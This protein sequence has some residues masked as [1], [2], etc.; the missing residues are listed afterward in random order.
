M[1]YMR[2]IP[3]DLFNEAKLLKCLGRLWIEAERNHPILKVTFGPEE[4][5]GN[6]DD[7]FEIVQD[8]GTG[9]IFVANVFVFVDGKAVH[10]YTGLNAREDWP[11]YADWGDHTELVFDEGGNVRQPF[12]ILT[13]Y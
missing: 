5:D 1:S 12:L 10:V 2:V 8:A 9:A 3:R 11:M 6:R 13:S 4:G 7:P